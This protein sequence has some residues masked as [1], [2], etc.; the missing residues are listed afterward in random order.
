MAIYRVH[1]PAG[2]DPLSQ[3]DRTRFVRDRF[4]VS[5]LIF[6][7]L[8]LLAKRQWLALLV[9]IAGATIVGAANSAGLATEQTAGAL[10]WLSALYL[11]FEGRNLVSAALERSGAP[12]VDIAAGPDLDT[13]ERVFFSRWSS[14]PDRPNAVSAGPRSP[15]AAAASHSIIGLFPEVGG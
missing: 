13:A 14:A 7:P 8:W 3:A 1:A 5:A 12:L 10:Y 4:S 6:G 15:A 9:W 2:L 11:G